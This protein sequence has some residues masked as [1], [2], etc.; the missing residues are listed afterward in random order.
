MR[1]SCVLLA[2]Q[3]DAIP[4]DLIVFPE[5]ICQ[6]EIDEACVR[7]P[8][9]MVVGA[10]LKGNQSRGVLMHQGQNR[11]DYLKVETDGRTV[12]SGDIQQAPV[13]EWN[14]VCV[15]V[16]ICMDI[17]HVEFSKTVIERV[18]SSAAALKMVCVPADM[19]AYWLG[20][21]CLPDKFRGAYVI[22][23]NHIKT[24]QIRCPSFVANRHGRKIIVQSHHEPIHAELPEVLSVRPA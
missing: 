15:A 21:E 7:Q 20:G 9:A 6:R 12:G 17:D 13:Y 3:L 24:H 10:I 1:I 16:L 19:G 18:R 2:R 11:I 5:G 23:C 4:S 22:L 8:N 14:N